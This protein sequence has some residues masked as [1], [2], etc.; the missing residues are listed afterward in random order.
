MWDHM[1][2]RRPIGV[3]KWL[4]EHLVRIVGY[5]S[6]SVFLYLPLR[7]I[8]LTVDHQGTVELFLAILI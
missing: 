8:A 4:F 5:G 1:I 2:P 7:R 3:C 6:T